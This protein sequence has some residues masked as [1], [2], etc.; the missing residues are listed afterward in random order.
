MP[1]SVSG[2]DDRLRQVLRA[3]PPAGVLALDE[4]DRAALADLVADARA[5]QDRSLEESFDRTLK[6]VPFPVRKI[7]KKVLTG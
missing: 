7:V 3:D 5:R 2:A 1:E 6:H 4:A